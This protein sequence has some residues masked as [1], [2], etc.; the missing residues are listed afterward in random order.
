MKRLL[1]LVLFLFSLALAPQAFAQSNSF[2]SI[3][4]PIRGNDFW[5]LK[6]QKPE[7]AVLGQIEILNKFN[8]PATWLIRFDALDNKDVADALKNRLTDEIGLFLEITPSWAQSANVVYHKS[9][10]WYSAGSAFLTGYEQDERK[11]L[12]D[13]A[14][15]KFKSIFGYFP[16]SAG[17]WWI[18]SFSLGYMREKYGIS[19]TLIVSDQYSTD[20]YQIWGQYFG[21]PYYPSKSNALHPAQSMENKL[22]IV[23]MQWALRD[24]VNSYGN[25]VKE[26]TF[27]VQANDYT[28]YHNLDRK[29]FSSLVDIYTKQ[30]FNQF[31][32]LTVGLENSYSWSKYANEYKSQVE[33]LAN[34]QSSNQFTIVLMKNFASWYKT[35]FPKLSPQQIII[36]DDPLGSFKK[37]VWF[38]DPYYRAGWF[39]NSEGSVF[40]D[41]RQYIDGQE[42]LCLKTRCDS[43]N[44]AT[45]AIR[46]LDEVSFGNRWVIDTGEINNFKSERGGEKFI[47]SYS[48]AA[49]HVRTIEFLPRD[50]GVDGKIYS[51]DSTI[52]NAIKKKDT[53]ENIALGETSLKLSPVSIVFNLIKF[54]AFIVLAVI[55]PGII[56][57]RKFIEKK[58][59]FL[60]LFIS[61]ATGLVMVTLLFYLTSLVNFK[62]LVFAYILINLIILIRLKY[63]KIL[64]GFPKI[65][66]DFNLVLFLIILSGTVF[67]IIP[68]FKSGLNFEYGTGFWG[69]NTHDGIWHMALINQLVKSVPPENPIF[70]GVI[71]KNYHYFY[72]L[73]VAA[74][75]YLSKVSITDL[76]FRF[77]PVMFSLMLGIGSYYLAMRL[78]KNDTTLVLLRNKIAIFFSLY[79]I[80][81]AGSFGWIVEYLREKHFGGESAFWVNQAVSFNLNPPFAI[82]LVILIALL[83]ILFSNTK[84]ILPKIVTIFIAGTLASFKSYT[85]ILVLAAL[86]IVALVRIF[87]NKDFNYFWIAL[88][89][90][91]ITA[92]LFLYNFQA[93][94]ALIIF[95]PFWFIHSMVD[96]PD[97]VG[98]VRLSLAR[99]A[100]LSLGQWP[101]FFMAE[102]L[103]LTLFIVGNL[104]L[105]FFA[106][107]SLVKIKEIFKNDI[108]LFIFVLTSFSVVI[109]I[110]FIQSGNPW[111]TIQ[112][113]YPVLYTTAFLSGPVIAALVIR[114]NKLLAFIIVVIVLV[115][116]PINSLV[117]AGGYFGKT[118][119]AFVSTNELVG[120]QFI[121]KQPNG[122]ILTY[123]FDEKLKT[124]IAEPWPILAYD[125]TAYVSA[126]SKKAVY[127]EDVGQNQIL[128]TDYKKRQVTSYDF[129]QRPMAGE[130]KFLGD[131]NIK[132]IYLPKIFNTRLDE[133]TGVIKNIF[134]NEE[135]VIYKAN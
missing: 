11:K 93:S 89:S 126:F 68:T 132:Y 61:S 99:T 87:R 81:F 15:A 74:T 8:L 38:M 134:E 105:R 77:Y 55:L 131:N 107:G 70:S 5:D 60:Q 66:K 112:F 54:L 95:A 26:S 78:F 88:F 102:T 43:V 22:D 129:F 63:Y 40:R 17:A 6:D 20:N 92:L 80:Y 52:L 110:L 51:I 23:M 121:A 104:G 64:T 109:P 62:P 36:A 116:T 82:S 24:P 21:T 133:S 27:S 84:G 48:N 9:N 12:I 29:Y 130:L 19:G 94:S 41:I 85:G 103:S 113:F 42:E 2:V 13:S 1:L 32:Y 25:G 128:L 67:Q 118:P 75:N 98:W 39:F 111:N 37:T 14:F 10:S 50:I 115:L 35:A 108:L 86:I 56:L 123:P 114:L 46:V 57:T 45:G 4:N 83:H 100:S 28:D 16:S 30:K 47:V 34:K 53:P 124:R 91:M 71:L 79:L 106:L 135:V 59:L 101:K 58:A 120:L 33:T 96:S 69:P 18:D 76:I 125:S 72:D 73:L 44:F 49:G 3:V 122:T 119:H 127:L 7:T 65:K 90:L 117:T 97:R 31:G